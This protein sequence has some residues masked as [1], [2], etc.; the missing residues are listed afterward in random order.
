MGLRDILTLLI[1]GEISI[2]DAVKRIELFALEN[3]ERKATIDIGREYRIGSPEIIWARYKSPELLEKIINS[4]LNKRGRVILSD[5]K[6][7]HAKVIEKFEGK[8]DTIVKRAGRVVVI[9]SSSHKLMKTGGKVGIITGGTADVPLA[10]EVR[11]LCEE[12]GCE[13]LTIYDI[14]IA[15]LHRTIET[16]K[17]LIEYDV[18]VVVVIAGMEGALPSIVKALI[19]VPVIGLPSSKGYGIG[20]EGLAALLSMLQSCSPGLLVVNIDNSVG[21]ALGAASIA[22]RVAKYREKM[23]S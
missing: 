14:G 9:K 4:V 18:D 5:V 8:D 3:L 21:A 13:T 22:N 23:I 20:G 16:V 7:E 6:E 10:K 1:R 15:G 11:L 2:D 17:K 19:D 12:M